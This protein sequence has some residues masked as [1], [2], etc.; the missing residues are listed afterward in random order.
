MNRK[1]FTLIELLATILIL[2]AI[3][4][5]VVV[6]VTASLGRRE[7]KECE[8]QKE[9]AI[10]AGKIY[11]SLNDKVDSITVG[12]LKDA[13]YFNETSK[14]DRLSESLIIKLDGN[15]YKLYE[16]DGNTEFLCPQS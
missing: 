5:V 14:T 9:L 16:E 11:F 13:N 12:E 15:I 8:E 1:G 10:N 4:I 6:S 3:S 7:V 2:S